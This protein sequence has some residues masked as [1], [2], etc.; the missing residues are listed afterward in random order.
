MKS[1][2]GRVMEWSNIPRRKYLQLWF[3]SHFKVA[4]RNKNGHE[5]E[6]KVDKIDDVE[7][8]LKYQW[9]KKGRIHIYVHGLISD[10]NIQG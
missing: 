9:L 1:H 2:K 5:M 4:R 10:G 8:I 6:T 7:F 3:V